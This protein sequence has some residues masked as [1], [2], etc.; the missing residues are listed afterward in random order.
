[1]IKTNTK[2]P[3]TIYKL[4]NTITNKAYIGQTTVDLNLRITQHKKPN[5][6]I[7]L[8]NAIQK[9]G[10]KNF[11]VEI[12]ATTDCLMELNTLEEFYIKAGQ[13]LAPMGYNLQ[14]GGG[15]SLRHADT[16]LKTSLS[17]KGKQNHLGKQHTDEAKAKM[18]QAHK[19]RGLK[20]PIVTKV[21]THIEKDL[22]AFIY[23]YM[24]QPLKFMRNKW[25]ISDATIYAIL[26]RHD[27]PKK[28]QKGN[29]KATGS[30]RKHRVIDQ[31]Q[32]T[33]DYIELTLAQV[34]C[35]YGISKGTIYHWNN[36]FSIKNKTK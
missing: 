31:E 28:G 35:K 18:R 11:R 4:T 10:W 27:I 9:Y 23:D 15:N 30:G 29:G 24:H 5:G 2:E 34:M 33:N 25:R 32:Y 8:S 20:H 14:S 1:M 26:R 13:T 12:L 21:T 17:M 36:R 3:Y 7:Y 16:K 22:N 6:C 19:E